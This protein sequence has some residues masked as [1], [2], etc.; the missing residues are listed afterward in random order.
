[1]EILSTITPAET[2]LL[3]D[4]SSA[5]LKDLMKLTFMDLL[6]KK[7][8][9][10]KLARTDVEINK[11]FIG[12]YTYVVQG[13]NLKTYSAKRHED[14]FM[15]PFL[16]NPSIQILFIHFIKM[17]YDAANGSMSYKGL[18]RKSPDL[19]G[20]FKQNM[21][22]RLFGL[23]RLTESGKKVS[24]DTKSKLRVINSK[25]NSLL[26]SD[27]KAGMEIVLPLK[28]NIF[29][30]KNLDFKL[31]REIDKAILSH[32]REKRNE[33]YDSGDDWWYYHDY[34][35]DDTDNYNI[36]DNFNDILDSYDEGFDATDDAATDS[37][38]DSG[39]GGCGD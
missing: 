28:G 19:E 15:A 34:F 16:M 7:V 33:S 36:F 8:L 1:M 26:L 37:S 32:L 29:L 9:D 35:E 5:S 30:L 38:C 14:I 6:H 2:K 12:A 25:I 10:L 27:P 31:I 11:E 39:C 23:S 13:K 22:S 21:I 18:I 20:Y 24:A 17:T 4:T 3:I